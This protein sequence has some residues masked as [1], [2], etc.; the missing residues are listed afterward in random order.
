MM[1]ESLSNPAA[2]A[3]ALKTVW[4]SSHIPTWISVL[5]HLQDLEGYQEIA[6][7]TTGKDAGCRRRQAAGDMAA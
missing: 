5:H 3:A 7:Q 1:H 6:R 2:A 4:V